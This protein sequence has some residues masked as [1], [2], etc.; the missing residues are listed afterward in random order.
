MR[1]APK[2]P[3]TLLFIGPCAPCVTKD[4]R[5]WRAVSEQHPKANLII[6]SRD[7]KQ[8]IA[9]FIKKE[10][11]PLPIFEDPNG[12]LGKSFN[13]IWIPRAYQVGADG[14]LLWVQ[15]DDA[16]SPEAIAGTLW[17]DARR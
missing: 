12:A 3:A 9:K 16:M 14:T 5:R 4:L 15:K 17:Q 10:K 8:N 1:N 2:R 13:A 6:V 7:T 11:I